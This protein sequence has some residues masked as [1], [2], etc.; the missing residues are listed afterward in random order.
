MVMGNAERELP[1]AA[2]WDDGAV[3]DLGRKTLQTGCPIPIPGYRQSAAAN[4]SR[5]FRDELALTSVVAS[6]PICDE[7]AQAGLTDF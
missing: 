1:C 3:G 5:R 2:G 4:A 6:R 7:C